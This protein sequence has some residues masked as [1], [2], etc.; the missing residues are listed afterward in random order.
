MAYTTPMEAAI[1]DM[2]T[3]K[4]ILNFPQSVLCWEM[5]T[6]SLQSVSNSPRAQPGDLLPC[7]A[8]RAPND[9]WPHLDLSVPWRHGPIDLGR[10]FIASHNTHPRETHFGTLA[11]LNCIP[12]HRPPLKR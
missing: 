3:R 9:V 12:P 6:I 1:D 2:V 4:I 10:R 8:T 7:N 11:G 5:R